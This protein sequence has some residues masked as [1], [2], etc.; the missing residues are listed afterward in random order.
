MPKLKKG[1]IISKNCPDCGTKLQIR[2]NNTTGDLFI[3]C[4][5]WPKCT[6]TE[7]LSQEF[8]MKAEGQPSM[9]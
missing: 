1:E 2:Q 8:I 3:G 4:P 6:H 9:F 7:E 5:N